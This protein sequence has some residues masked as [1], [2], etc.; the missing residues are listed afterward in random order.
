MHNQRSIE[1]LFSGAASMADPEARSAYLRQAC[2]D[3]LALRRKVEALCNPVNS[4][5]AVEIGEQ[6]GDQVGPYLLRE[7]LGEG[8]FG[9]VFA[10]EQ[11]SPIR[12]RVAL[13]ILKPGRAE[14]VRE[15]PPSLV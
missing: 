9:V 1:E 13:K 15:P 5:V 8:G 10:A 2:G 11:Q 4:S 12:R 3:D 14:L 7:R 6:A